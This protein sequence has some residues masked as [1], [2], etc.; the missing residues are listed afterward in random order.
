[1]NGIIPFTNFKSPLSTAPQNPGKL[2][3]FLP[4]AASANGF[5]FFNLITATGA[6]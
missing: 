6:V 1:M 2:K 4:I 5:I 3:N